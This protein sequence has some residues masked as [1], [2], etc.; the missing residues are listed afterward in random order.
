MKT[1]I[2]A[3]PFAITLALSA[4]LLPTPVSAN[5]NNELSDAVK[6]SSVAVHFRYRLEYVDQDNALD[7]AIASTLRSRLTVNSGNAY[8][9]SAIV[10]LDNVS[11]LGNDNYNSTV[12]GNTNYSIV[13]DP[14]GTDINQASLRY[15]N[16]SGTSFSAGRQLV[17]H[18]NQRFLGGVGWRQNEQTL[19]GY[20]LQQGFG[21][22]INAELGHYHN[23]NRVFGPKGAAADQ[24]GSFN[25]ALLQWQINP[26]HQL[27]AFGYDFEF[28]SWAARSSRTV[29]IDYQGKLTTGPKLSWHF[30]LA[31][32]DDAHNAPL[33]V[34]HHYHR[35]S[36]NWA[37]DNLTLQAGQERLAGNSQSAFQTPLATL[38]AFSGFADLFLNT[39]N[40]G[41]RDNWLEA[42][43]KLKDIAI[44][45][46]YHRFDS[47]L[48]SQKYGDEWNASAGYAV[49]K[50]LSALVKL[51]H[52]QTDSL[53]VDTTK[54]WLML[55][56]QP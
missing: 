45:L 46:A 53:A 25:T 27:A 4:S 38:H 7:D 2:S 41:L 30:A 35:L 40:T 43:T 50:Q 24:S 54:V 36:L 52:Y 56:Y 21:E 39:P 9:F 48:G 10:Q 19:D 1:A 28:D 5:T 31:K 42:K 11:A 3:L 29:G 23:V 55:S 16:N 32:Q 37:F 15:T 33:N 18:M 6:Q 12:N 22:K 17:N 51:A 34:S 26:A 14:E 47:D 20:R 8:G 44:T 49:N 13:A